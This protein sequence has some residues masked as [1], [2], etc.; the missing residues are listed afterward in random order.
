MSCVN[1][2][3]YCVLHP[4]GVEKMELPSNIGLE[5]SEPARCRFPNIINRQLMRTINA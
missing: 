3:L 2:V 1:W 5:S 4:V